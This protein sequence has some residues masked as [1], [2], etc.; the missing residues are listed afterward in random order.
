[1]TGTITRAFHDDPVWRWAFPDEELRP[2][3]FVRWWGIFV[4]AALGHGRAWVTDACESVA[5]WIP[6]GVEEFTRD[7][8]RRAL[9]L[10]D[11]MLGSRAPVVKQMLA[12]FDDAH[13]H[14]EPHYY[15]SIVA[16]D[17]PFR[18]RGIGAE[19]LAQNLALVDAEH[20]PAYLESS[21]PANH[22][23]YQRLGFEPLAEFL[24]G[25]D[26]PPVLTLW[27]PAR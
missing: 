3:Q 20:M 21:N 22:A 27:R 23:R 1:M 10:I 6:P 2:A 9:A 17:N 5:L 11:E 25:P 26:G 24:T 8:A 4:E 7:E 16:T 18:G 19:L 15:L 14:D 12:N 13:P